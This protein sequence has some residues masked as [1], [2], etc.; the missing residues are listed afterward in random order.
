MIE[1]RPRPGL[2][3]RPRLVLIVL[4]IFFMLLV[5]RLW[6]LQV[7]QAGRFRELGLRNRE[8]SVNVRPVR[9]RGRAAASAGV[10][11]EIKRGNPVIKHDASARKQTW[12]G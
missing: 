8:R 11:R 12:G 9:G 7:V 10:G 1:P 4:A 6:S 5:L 3:G 2:T